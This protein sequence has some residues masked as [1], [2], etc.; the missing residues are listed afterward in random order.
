MVRLSLARN[1]NVSFSKLRLLRLVLTALVLVTI[2]QAQAT[3]KVIKNLYTP[4]PNGGLIFDQNG[5]LYG[6]TD[7]AYRKYGTVFKLRHYSNGVWGNRL[8][9]GF[10]GT[11][12]GAYPHSHPIFDSAGNLY[13]AT[14]AG[15]TNYCPY[16]TQA[17]SCGVVFELMPTPTG[18][19]T[20]K[21]LYNFKGGMDGANPSAG[22][23]SDS[24][25]NLYGT[26]A[27]GGFFHGT[28]FKLMH[29]PNGTW[30]EKVLYR[31]TGDTD[32]G[33]PSGGLVLDTAGNLYGTTVIGGNT[34]HGTIFELSPGPSGTWT[35]RSLHSFCS[36]VGCRDGAGSSLGVIL[37]SHGN[38]YGVTSLGGN[39]PCFANEAGCG[40]AFKL[41]RGQNG[42][43]AFNLL[44]LFCSLPACADGAQL[45]GGLIL[46]SAGNLYGT[47]T[48]G[49][50][51]NQGTVFKLSHVSGSPW[52]D[53]VLYSF[54]AL[55]QCADGFE[56]TGSLVRD[57]AGNL[58]GTTPVGSKVFEI[59][60]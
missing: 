2:A 22:V 8:L 42:T 43:W 51:A 28:V 16:T 20:E 23:I 46:D 37:D 19:W 36:R 11:T 24:A 6:T 17:L 41:S 35:F 34:G 12:D 49:G 26:T 59:I 33:G 39:V 27:F 5:N 30:S 32:G 58:Y 9:Y 56:P 13:G 31:F 60:P 44:Y 48:T 52:T 47:T 57:S 25:G 40:T 45:G 15:G 21:V 29:S 55:P 10:T 54:C 7:G 14:R 3:E 38:L 18:Q 4:N 1:K 50:S 53:D